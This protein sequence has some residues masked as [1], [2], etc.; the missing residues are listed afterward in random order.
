MLPN[1]YKHKLLVVEYLIK[2]KIF[3][4]FIVLFKEKM[5]I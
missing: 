3:K 4:S 5:L 1:L 2:N